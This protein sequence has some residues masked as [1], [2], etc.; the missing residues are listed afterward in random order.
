MNAALQAV[1]AAPLGGEIST[2]TPKQIADKIVR[3]LCHHPYVQTLKINVIN[4]GDGR[5]LLEAIKSLLGQD[6][7]EDFNFDLKFFSSWGTPYPLVASVFDE[8]MGQKSRD[9]WSFGVPLSETEE[10]LLSPNENPLFPKL[11]YGKYTI[12]ELLQDD[13]PQRFSAHLTF[14]IDFFSTSLSVRAY[15]GG[16]GSSS[17]YNLLAEYVTDYQAGKTT[18]AWS[19]LIAPSRCHDLASHGNTGR[20]YQG[21]DLAGHAVA[22]LFSWNKALQEYLTTQLELTDQHGKGHLRMLDRVH[23]ISDWVFTIDRNFGIEY[24]DDPIKGPGA[25]AGGY[26][27][28]YTPEFLDG[29]AHRLII[30]TYHQQEIE[31]ILRYGFF[32]LLGIDIE[33]QGEMIN[34]AKIA[35]VLGL[36]KSVSGRLALKLINNPNQAQEVIGLALTRLA[37]EQDD[38]LQGRVLIPVDSHIGLFY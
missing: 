7:Y 29:V 20:L 11:I 38:R 26:L 32:D 5:L 33:Q 8:F 13:D 35:Y 1:G 31:N 16:D 34:T 17:L 18:A 2:V 25:G 10:R 23:E 24:F 19:R 22:S 12:D 36:L 30:S 3:Y 4:P 15:P 9:D 37:L 14:V 28:D 21:Q 6:L 27:I